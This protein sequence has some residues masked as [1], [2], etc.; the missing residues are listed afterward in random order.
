MNRLTTVTIEDGEKCIW[1][2]GLGGGE[3]GYL[4]CDTEFLAAERLAAYE[5]TGL[6]PEEVERLNDFEQT[7]A[8][9]LLKELNAEQNKHRWIPVEERL[10]EDSNYI[11][12]SFANFSMTMLGRYEE[13]QEGGAFYLGDD[14]DHDTYISRNLI[15]NAWQ[16]LPEPYKEDN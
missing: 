11:L 8:G 3:T 15:V 14:I 10:P 6:S 12:L 16:P 13:D 2:K 4:D 9:H 1:V 5:D 7:Q